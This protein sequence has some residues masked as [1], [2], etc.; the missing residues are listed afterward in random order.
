M[1][2]KNNIGTSFHPKST[3]ILNPAFNQNNFCPSQNAMANLNNYNILK[4][5]ALPPTTLASMWKS[6]LDQSTDKRIQPAV[7]LHDLASIKC[8]VVCT[9]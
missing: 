7:T 5:H 9:T 2:N 4:Q 8:P 3:S 1:F 6:A